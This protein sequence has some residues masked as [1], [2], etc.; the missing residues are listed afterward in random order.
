MAAEQNW[1]A[2]NAAYLKLEAVAS[3]PSQAVLTAPDRFGAVL[4][5]KGSFQASRMDK[6]SH[7]LN[8]KEK[9]KKI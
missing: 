5:S 1:L 8:L 2:N 6:E 9:K 3:N 4:S 7:F